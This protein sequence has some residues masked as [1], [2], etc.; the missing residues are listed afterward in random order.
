MYGPAIRLTH[1]PPRAPPDSRGL[2]DTA[3]PTSKALCTQVPYVQWHPMTWRAISARPDLRCLILAAAA[4]FREQVFFLLSTFGPLWMSSL[5]RC[6]IEDSKST[7]GVSPPSR[8]LCSNRIEER[9]SER[10]PQTQ[11]RQGLVSDCNAVREHLWVTRA[12]ERR[13]ARCDCADRCSNLGREPAPHRRS[14]RRRGP[15]AVA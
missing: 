1:P 3:R 12:S 13:L 2:V 14:R 9:C 15:G 8:C 11:G 4:H 6:L 7:E 5:L 10:R